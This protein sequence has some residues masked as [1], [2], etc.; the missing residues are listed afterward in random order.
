MTTI[1]QRMEQELVQYYDQAP[2]ISIEE[3]RKLESQS[4][5][6]GSVGGVNGI[7]EINKAVAEGSMTE[8]A[9][10]AILRSIYGIDLETAARMVEPGER[11]SFNEE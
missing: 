5:I 7:I 2:S 4:R 10:E 8:E 3:E 6:R 1:F 9:G 11:S